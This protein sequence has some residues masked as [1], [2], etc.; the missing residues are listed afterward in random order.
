MFSDPWYNLVDNNGNKI[1]YR[2]SPLPTPDDFNDAGTGAPFVRLA[3]AYGLTIPIPMLNEYVLPNDSPN[4][5]PIY[6]R[7][8][9]P[10]RDDLYPR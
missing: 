6:P 5:T 9:L 4:Q 2:V 1:K 10:D 3:V 7:R 8:D